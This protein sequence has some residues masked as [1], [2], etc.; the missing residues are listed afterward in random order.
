M[1]REP[2]ILV[3][4]RLAAFRWMRGRAVHEPHEDAG[5]QP[6]PPVCV[7]RTPLD[8]PLRWVYYLNERRFADII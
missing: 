5:E 2:T 8:V 4:Q 6:L 3:M 7:R 1:V